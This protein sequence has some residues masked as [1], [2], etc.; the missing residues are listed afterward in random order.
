METQLT[1]ALNSQREK[2][3]AA[4]I[5]VEMA[6]GIHLMKASV[7]VALNRVIRVGN[8]RGNTKHFQNNS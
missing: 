6:A 1:F 5:C 8:L 3:E 2:L 4:T 7:K